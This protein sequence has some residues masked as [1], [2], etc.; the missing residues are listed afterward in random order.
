MSLLGTTV[1]FSIKHLFIATMLIASAFPTIGMLT[2]WRNSYIASNY[3]QWRVVEGF[4]AFDNGDHLSSFKS[5]FPNAMPMPTHAY[6]SWHPSLKKTKNDSAYWLQ[7]GTSPNAYALEVLFQ[8]DR[9]VNHRHLHGA[10][11]RYE[12][13]TMGI[14]APSWHVRNSTILFFAVIASCLLVI[15]ILRRRRGAQQNA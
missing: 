12:A 13:E 3:R 4:H 8:N 10:A 2:D 14:S 15:T 11:L 7:V 6:Y 1:K 9:I 5:R